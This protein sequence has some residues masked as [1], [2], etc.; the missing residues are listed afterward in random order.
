MNSIIGVGTV[1]SREV[2][3]GVSIL[4]KVG[5]QIQILQKNFHT[6]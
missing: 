4:C 5:Q 2:G 3:C 1:N 6:I